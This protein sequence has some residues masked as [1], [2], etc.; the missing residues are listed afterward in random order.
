M[1]DLDMSISGA[2][3]V[4]V[5]LTYVQLL[6]SSRCMDYLLC[7]YY[8]KIYGNLQKVCIY[9]HFKNDLKYNNLFFSWTVHPESEDNLY[10]I[11]QQ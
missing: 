2:V 11:G 10:F 6:Q 7:T 3:S 9:Y 1:A 8:L 4:L 5:R